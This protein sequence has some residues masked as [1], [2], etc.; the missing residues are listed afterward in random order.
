MQ[1]DPV[2][3]ILRLA[4]RDRVTIYT[5]DDD[6]FDLDRWERAD[7]YALRMMIGATALLV[8]VLILAIL[9]VAR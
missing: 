4:R 6:A 9:G 8:I 7:R 3:E 2:H 5:T 1:D